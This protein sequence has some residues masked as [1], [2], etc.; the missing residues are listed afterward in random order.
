LILL[1]ALFFGIEWLGRKDNH[2]LQNTIEKYP[3]ALRFAAYYLVAILVLVY[4]SEGKEQ[5]FIYFQF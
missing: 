2:A 4:A 3:K 1:I 5:Q